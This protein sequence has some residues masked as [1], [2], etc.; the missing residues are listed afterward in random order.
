MP[1]VH[2]PQSHSHD[3]RQ[4]SVVSGPRNQ[5]KLKEDQYISPLPEG[6]LLARNGY[7]PKTFSHRL[8]PEQ[9]SV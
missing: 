8:D 2:Q 3:K 4:L 1:H 7:K 6:P 5:L 9:T